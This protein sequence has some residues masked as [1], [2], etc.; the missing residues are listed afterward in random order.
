MEGGCEHV[1]GERTFET[2]RE[3]ERYKK[4][5]PVPL[6]LDQGR[7]TLVFEMLML[8]DRQ[9]PQSS[10]C[11]KIHQCN[12]DMFFLTEPLTDTLGRIH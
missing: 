4:E 2:E 7:M 1:G 9:R 10:Q 6:A 8:A 5:T 3:G 12:P 11:T